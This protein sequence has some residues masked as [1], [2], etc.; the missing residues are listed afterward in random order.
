MEETRK[1]VLAYFEAWTSRRTDDAFAQLAPDLEFV[2]PTS[3]FKSAAAFKPALEGF[4]K[5]AKRAQ[6]V[7]L[8][9]DGNR[10]AMLY[11]CE[12]PFGVVRIMS[13]FR[14]EGGRI[15]WYET[16]FDATELRKFVAK[17]S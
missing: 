13:F 4:A 8:L 3:S 14:V 9:V 15:R 10:A 16:Q 12:L 11:E 5:L 6:I 17:G 2:G 7:E 1:T